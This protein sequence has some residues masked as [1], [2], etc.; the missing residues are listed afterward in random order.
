MSLKGVARL[1]GAFELATLCAE[2]E[3]APASSARA[4]SPEAVREIEAQFNLVR[5]SSR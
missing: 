1:L 5:S 3:S 4:L 2:M